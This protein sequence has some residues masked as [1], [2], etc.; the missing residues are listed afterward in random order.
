MKQ[1]PY[2]NKDIN[3][4]INVIDGMQ[5]G[6]NAFKLSIIDKDKWARFVRYYFNVD[7]IFLFIK[8]ALTGRGGR[9]V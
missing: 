6:K 2:E 1:P 8:G 7:S 9:V 3:M 4:K 5:N